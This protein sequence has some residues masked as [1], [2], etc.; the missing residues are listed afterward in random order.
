MVQPSLRESFEAG[1]RAFDRGAFWDAHEAWEERWREETDEG[2][3]RVLQGLIQVAAA[4]HKLVVMRSPASAA[5]LF[6]KGLAK[7]EDLP[8]SFVVDLRPFRDGVAA[9]ARALADGR[10]DEA[11]IPRLAPPSP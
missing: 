6:A 8:A 11:S 5:R 4:L 7:L 9:C 1:A 3:R 10:F 2:A